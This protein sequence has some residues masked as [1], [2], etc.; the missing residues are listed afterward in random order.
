MEDFALGLQDF[1]AGAKVLHVGVPDVGHEDYVGFHH[2]GEVVDFARVVHAQLQHGDFV[3]VIQTEQGQGE[4]D[5]TVHVALGFQDVEAFAQDGGGHV[6]GGGFAHRAGE[7]YHRDGKLFSVAHSQVP[8][9]FEGVLYLD[10]EFSRQVGFA[11]PLGEAACR[12]ALQGGVDVDMTVHS[13]AQQGDKQCARVDGS[14]VRLHQGY[15]AV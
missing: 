3:G 14:A 2:G 10:V 8:E 1:F 5:F 12:A 13:L 15:L 11:L 7:G 4:A 9:G 6:L